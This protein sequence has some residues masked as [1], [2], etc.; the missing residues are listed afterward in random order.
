M[1]YCKWLWTKVS[2]KM[3]MFWWLKLT[4]C[5]LLSLVPDRRLCV[6]L[7]IRLDEILSSFF[8]QQVSFEN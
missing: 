4:H 8:S 7:D 5:H 6:C 1:D 3:Q 2:A